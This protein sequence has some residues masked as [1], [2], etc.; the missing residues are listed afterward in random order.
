MCLRRQFL[1]EDVKAEPV[2]DADQIGVHLGQLVDAFHLLFQEM[3]FKVVAQVRIVVATSNL[4]QFQ[5]RLQNNNT[6][7][8]LNSKKKIKSMLLYLVDSFLQIQN[9]FKCDQRRRPFLF[10]WTT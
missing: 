3:L 2:S 5:Q 9:R 7:L 8:V 4:V 6:K 1:V 10:R